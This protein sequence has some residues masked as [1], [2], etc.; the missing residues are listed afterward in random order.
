M[1]VLTGIQPTNFLHIGNLFGALRPAIDL[2]RENDL[3]MMIADYHA[4]TA[5]HDPVKLHDNILFTAASY[6][7]AGIDPTKTVLFQQS[8]IPAHT[9]L[10][11]VL[12]TVAR[13]GEA[14]RMTQFKDKSGSNEDKVSV[15]LFTYPTLMAADILLYDAESVPV[16]DDQKQHIE[17]TRDLAQRFN[18]DFGDTFVVPE[19]MIRK[20]GARLKSLTEPE[21]KMSKSAPS[22]K[23]YISLTDDPDIIAK[24]VRSAT[25]D[26]E[27]GMTFSK[28][29]PG[30]HNLLTILSLIEDAPGDELASRY[31]GMGT[32]ALK[33][34]LTERLVEHLR[35]I[36]KEAQNL[37]DNKDE[38]IRVIANGT[39]AAAK[40]ANAKIA[41]VRERIGV[42][43]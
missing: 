2:Q 7:A 32:K 14:K 5:E 39:A 34:D 20:H 29:R 37:V 9:E 17:F 40:V 21:K 16:G 43:L 19:P 36:S 23:S 11:W 33:D 4:I 38:L 31:D 22:A 25:T 12:Q 10:G 18:R 6:I 26:S 42:A 24:K 27:P 35:P 41:E 3:F 15:G 1:R 13:M 28:D 8:Q 30:L